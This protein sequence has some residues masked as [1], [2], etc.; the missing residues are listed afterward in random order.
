MY[1]NAPKVAS[2]SKEKRRKGGHVGGGSQLALGGGC[3]LAG[4]RKKPRVFFLGGR[5]KKKKRSYFCGIV[6]RA[7]K[8][9]CRGKKQY[10]RN[11]KDTF[12]AAGGCEGLVV[13]VKKALTMGS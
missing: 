13:G 6:W 3:I 5:E 8:T 12:S 11:K 9:N 7:T 10:K 4:G 1:Q 2:E